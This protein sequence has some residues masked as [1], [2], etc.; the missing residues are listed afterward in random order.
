MRDGV[1]VQT[2]YLADTSD[3]MIK[4][5]PICTENNKIL[6]KKCMGIFSRHILNSYILY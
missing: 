1:T 2:E 5:L 3:M 6:Q 4:Y